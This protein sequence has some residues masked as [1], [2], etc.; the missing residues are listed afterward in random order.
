VHWTLGILPPSQAVFYASAFSRSDGV[1]SSAPAPVT[2]TVGNSL[3]SNLKKGKLHLAKIDNVFKPI[4]GKPCWQV[5]Q[6]YGS[7][8]TFEFGEPRLRIQ[9]PR[10]ASKQASE[11]LRKRWA[12]RNFY[13][14]GDWHLWI[15]ICDWRIFLNNE[16]LANDSSARK[17]IKNALLEIDGQALISITIKKS[18]VCIFEFDLGGRLEITPNYEDYEKDSDLWLLYKPSGY[19]FT[20]RADGKHNYAPGDGSV[21][22]AWKALNISKSKVVVK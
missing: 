9:E 13:I 22:K 20:L 11:K 15:Y 7:F 19:V 14:R 3:Q 10:Q 12:R 6:G 5:Q 4:I 1:A 17:T 8:L 2:H 21:E 18:Y 16:E